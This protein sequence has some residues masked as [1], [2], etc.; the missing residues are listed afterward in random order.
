MQDTHSINEV[1]NV[2]LKS[3]RPANAEKYAQVGL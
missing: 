1:L 3:I 2:T